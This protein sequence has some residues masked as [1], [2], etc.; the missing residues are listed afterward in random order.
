TGMPRDEA[1]RQAH[2]EFGAVEAYKEQ[3]RDA[4][5]FASL[6]VLHGFGADLKVASRRLL[7]TPM[8]T[9]FAVLSLAL[10]VGVTTAVY[11]SVDTVLWKDRVIPE[12]DRVAV[13]M[14]AE[15]GQHAVQGV[16]S[17]PDFEDFRAAQQSFTRITGAYRIVP[18]VVTPDTTIL[19]SGEAV[20]EAYFDTLGA[21]VALGRPVQ[22]ADVET[23][24]PVVVLGHW[25]WRSRFAGDSSIIGRTI[26][27]AG[28]PF[29]VIGVAPD[30]F[31]G[32]VAG[33]RRPQL[34]VPSTTI[35]WFGVAA[36]RTVTT[37]ERDRRRLTVVGRLR[38]GVTVQ[39]ASA[40]LG[41]FA[42]GLDAAYPRAPRAE[43]G[44][45]PRR[46]WFAKKFD[47]TDRERS[48]NLTAGLLIVGLVGLVLVV[49]CTNLSN[50]MLARGTMRHQELA[51]R[52]ALGAPRWRLVREQ[53]AET[54]LIAVLGGAVSFVVL[55]VL[56]TVLNVEIPIGPSMVVSAQPQINAAALMATIGALLLAL[57]VFGLEPAL[58]I[59]GTRDVRDVLAAGGGSV[60]TPTTKR[61]HRL[62]RW[63]VAISAGFFII[64]SMSA[65]YL[66]SEAR[67][68]PGVVLDRMAVA[69]VSFYG[70]Q[71]D[72]T[73]ARGAVDRILQEG[74]RTPGVEAV[75][76]S[77][78]LP[79]G[80]TI[81]PSAEISTPDKPI[82]PRG[83]HGWAVLMAV[84]PQYFRAAGTP[85]LR[86]RGFD[87]RDT[88][89]SQRVVIIGESAARELFGTSDAV[90]R[91]ILLKVD[92]RGYRPEEEVRRVTVAG[93]AADADTTHYSS[94]RG[95][96]VYLPF[97]QEYAPYVTVIARTFAPDAVPALRQL[98][99]KAD[100]DVPIERIGTAHSI[101]A[102]PYVFLRAAGIV[103]VALGAL[104]LLLAMVGLY[105]VQSQAVAHRTREIGVR[106]SLGA[107]AAQV[108]AM[109]LK[110]GYKPVLQGL[111][112]GLFIGIAGRAIVRS[113][114][115]APLEIVDPWMLLVVPVPLLFAAFFACYLPARRASRVDPNVALR[116]L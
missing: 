53:L 111:A 93:V 15:A 89:A 7:A 60:G 4:S 78:G 17:V 81:T 97:A 73:K 3:C 75:A 2:V 110:D 16:V 64:A 56:M 8:F 43:G 113:V 5:G 65:R 20:D 98:I 35:G 25:L 19:T 49:A 69:I 33:P 41:S 38:P 57:A 34:W 54:L 51:V 29:E 70:S 91:E 72:E 47:D 112:I 87:D 45:P 96:T 84:T 40:E 28:R 79:F 10:G 44:G 95:H 104:T 100:P 101:L 108:R 77:T 116:H 37:P 90:G 26:R 85:L 103:A 105:G 6:R 30:G 48:M 24:A 52:G 12:S 99:R 82:Q 27:L 107:T 36:G 67:H 11:S 39:T 92:S 42:Q 106:M 66:A 68:D 83:E 55:R 62:L 114:M 1:V 63:Q 76:V 21:G 80:T 61:Q 58:R 94:R 13:V 115:V 46:G 18:S 14:G 102:G 109:V 59:T 32:A 88:A 50:L 22:R 71:W 31:Q 9:V 86:G 74:A 23:S